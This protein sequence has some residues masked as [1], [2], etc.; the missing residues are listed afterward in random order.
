MGKVHF[1][2]DLR[3]IGSLM[4]IF[5]HYIRVFWTGQPAVQGLLLM[6]QAPDNIGAITAATFPFYNYFF[7]NKYIDYGWLGVAI[8]FLIS[9]F[10][11]PFSLNRQ[12]PKEFL[13]TRFFRIYPAYWGASM[14]T[15]IVLYITGRYW[16][17]S[18]TYP[19]GVIW[20]Q[21]LLL[22]DVLGSIGFD[23][24]SWTLEIEVKF[25]LICILLYRYKDKLL[26]YFSISVI[27]CFVA[28]YIQGMHATGII[29]WDYFIPLDSCF[30]IYMFIGVVFNFLYRKL[31]SN[32]TAIIYTTALFILSTIAFHYGLM[33]NILGQ[34]LFNY[35]IA[36]LIFTVGYY[37]KDKIKGN[38]IFNFLADISYS[39]Y[40][41]HGVTGYAI[42]E[43]LI[44]RGLNK[45][46][47][48][49]GTVLFVMFIAYIIH[50][51]IEDPGRIFGK[52]LVQNIVK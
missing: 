45:Y 42:M 6:K 2:Q 25:Y 51:M 39:L 5:N 7:F 27:I 8:F 48:V 22:R 24:I 4:V 36:I 13:L 40:A 35:L 33:A 47:V 15:L 10:V 34:Y 3:A 1:V 11:I 31:I 29:K 32:S 18:A 46:C 14:V 43:I 49:V 28:Y 20:R 12:K 26:S 38:K 52:K 23:G 17:Y 37:Y 16:G 41:V 9:G 50:A 21:I 30:I 44:T 19:F